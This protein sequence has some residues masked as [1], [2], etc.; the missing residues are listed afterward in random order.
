MST[1]CRQTTLGPSIDLVSPSLLSTG[2]DV[3]PEQE[4]FPKG[5]KK[6]TER[7]SSTPKEVLFIEMTPRRTSTTLKNTS[8]TPCYRTGLSSR[9]M[10]DR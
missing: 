5:G 9:S 10:F 1:F 6:R 4:C 8:T 7:P 3:Y 2:T